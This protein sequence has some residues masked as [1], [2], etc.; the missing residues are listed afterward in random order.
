M[1]HGIAN[2]PPASANDVASVAASAMAAPAALIDP[3]LIG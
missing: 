1:S 3:K 2:A